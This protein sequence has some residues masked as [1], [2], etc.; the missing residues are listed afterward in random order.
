MPVYEDVEELANVG[1]EH[2][3]VDHSGGF[4]ESWYYNGDLHRE[5]G[6]ARV[7]G[8]LNGSIHE[9]HQNGKLHRIDGPATIKSDIESFEEEWYLRGKLIPKEEFQK[10]QE[11]PVADLVFHVNTDCA[12]IVVERLKNAGI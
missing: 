6:P 7:T 9:Y 12:P 4:M 5:G 1:Y 8:Y 10:V 3:R 11:C 2:H